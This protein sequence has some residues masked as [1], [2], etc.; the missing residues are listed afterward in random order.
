MSPFLAPLLCADILSDSVDF[1]MGIN[2]MQGHAAVRKMRESMWGG[3]S[4][5]L[6]F[7]SSR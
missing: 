7:R 3:K 6:L 5:S 2:A 4:P 1:V